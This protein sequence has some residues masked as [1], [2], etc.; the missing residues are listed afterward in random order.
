M[1]SAYAWIICLG[2]WGE[3]RQ[4]DGECEK[5]S[6][7]VEKTSAHLTAEVSENNSQL[8]SSTDREGMMDETLWAIHRN[9]VTEPLFSLRQSR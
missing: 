4:H 2:P 8:L 1:S 9:F 3:V 5:Y 6:V 7:A